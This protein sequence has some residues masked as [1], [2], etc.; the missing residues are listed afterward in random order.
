MRAMDRL[1]R[2]LDLVH[3]LQTAPEP[4]SFGQ[5]KDQFADYAE[6]SDEAIRRK[7]ERDKAELAGL[8][9]VLRYVEDE[10]SGAGY[11]LDAE[12]SYLPP[13]ELDEQERGVL[14]TASQAALADPA[15]PHRAAL[16]LALAKLGTELGE[17][18]PE[19]HFSRGFEGAGEDH[20]RIEAL[21]AALTS[22]KRVRLRYQKPGEASPSERDVDPYGLFV[23]R[24]VWYLV[25]LDH[26]SGEIRMFRVSR[27]LEVAVN[28]KRPGSPDFEVPDDFDLRAVMMTSPLRYQVH[29]PV[30]VT[31]RVDPEVA[32]LMEREWGAP[33]A[34]G[35]FTVET[36]YLDYVV[37]QV[38]SLGARAELLGPPEARARVADA[39][40][41]VLRAHEAMS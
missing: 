34:E 6:G 3:V 18:R 39:L 37:D 7:F 20:G 38:L 31:I 30:T 26:R 21:G 36:T 1:E 12:A 16:R 41:R 33:D 24:G 11:L 22:R 32:F 35:V 8:G 13:I 27:I 5:L 10:D 17:A 23:R 15:F 9:L 40:R 14:A 4:V 29:P 2:L 19:V 28:G 25:G